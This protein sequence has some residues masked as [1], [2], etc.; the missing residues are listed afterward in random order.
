MGLAKVGINAIGEG[1]PV[2]LCI[3]QSRWTVTIWKTG[4]EW[5]ATL[6]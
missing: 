5:M 4:R 1:E 6:T 2:S 3:S